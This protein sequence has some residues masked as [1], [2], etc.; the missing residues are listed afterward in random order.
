ME[1]LLQ[2]NDFLDFED[3]FKEL[4]NE[5]TNKLARKKLTSEDIVQAF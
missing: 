1:A 3:L 5:I 4:S 2:I